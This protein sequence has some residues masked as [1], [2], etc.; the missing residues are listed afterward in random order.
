MNYLLIVSILINLIFLFLFYSI[1]SISDYNTRKIYKCITYKDIQKD[2]KSG[3]ILLFSSYDYSLI[4]RT[5]GHLV[6]S[7][8]GIVVKH[9]Q[10]LYSLELTY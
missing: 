4:T 6:F 2:I 10:K 5:C 9:K 7:H 3:D 1:F 8:I